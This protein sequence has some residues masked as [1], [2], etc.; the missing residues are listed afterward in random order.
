MNF[1]QYH[2]PQGIPL[3]NV[4][5]SLNGGGIYHNLQNRNKHL[6]SLTETGKAH[7]THE[8]C[9]QYLKVNA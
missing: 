7:I 2:Y 6:P 1:K 4:Y 5:N 9:H 8:V 3:R